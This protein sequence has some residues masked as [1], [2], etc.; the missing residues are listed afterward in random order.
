MTD[1]WQELRTKVSDKEADK[2]KETE[3]D[4]LILDLYKLEVK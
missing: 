4:S 1:N 2:D 3:L